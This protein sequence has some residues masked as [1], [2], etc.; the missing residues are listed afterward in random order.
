MT[1]GERAELRAKAEA[2]RGGRWTA[3]DGGEDQYGNT[4]R[5][6]ETFAPPDDHDLVAGEVTSREYAEHI[7]AAHP[8]AVLALLDALER[9][10]GL[11]AEAKAFVDAASYNTGPAHVLGARIAAHLKGTP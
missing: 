3:M 10:E 7:A 11:L 9:A 8:A 1:G 4:P 2:A 5:W 6:V